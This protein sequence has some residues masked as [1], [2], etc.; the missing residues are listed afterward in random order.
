MTPEEPMEMQALPLALAQQPLWFLQRLDPSS[1]AYNVPLA[2]TLSGTLDAGRLRRALEA[3]VERHE[4]LRTTFESIEGEPVQVFH[5][6][7]EVPWEEIDLAGLPEDER[8]RAIAAIE[9]EEASRPFDLARGPLVRSRLARLADDEHVWFV[10]FHHVVF[11]GWSQEVLLDEL[12]RLYDPGAEAPPELPIQY[13]DFAAWQEE[14]LSG[15]RL[16]R[17]VAFWRRELEGYPTLL[18]LPTDSP[19]PARQSFRGA[20]VGATLPPEVWRRAEALADEAGATPFMIFLAI[21]TAVLHR[22]SGADRLLVGTPSA[23]R[24]HPDAEGLIGNFVNTLAIGCDLSGDPTFRELLGRVRERTVAALA[25]EEL[26]FVQ[27]VEAIDPERHP[28]FSPLAQVGVAVERFNLAARELAPGLT[29]ETRPPVVSTAKIDMILFVR[30]APEGV[31]L[32]LEHATDLF[33]RETAERWLAYVARLAENALADP[34]RRL[35]ELPLMAEEEKRLVLEEWPLPLD[36]ADAPR[37]ASAAGRW[38]TGLPAAFA[39]RAAEAP[40]AVAVEALGGPGGKTGICL[41]YAGLARRSAALA[42]RLRAA[43]VRR[44]TPVA[45]ALD[46]SPELVVALLAVVR[47]GGVYVPLDRSYPEERRRLM[48]EDAGVRTLLTSAALADGL[49]D[50][51]GIDVLRIG[52]PEDDGFGADGGWTDAPVGPDDAAYVI[53]TSGSTGKPKGVTATH[54]GVARLAL[55]ADFTRL[56]PDDTFLHLASI[57]FDAATLEVWGPLL[58][59]GRV[60]LFPAETPAPAA[61]RSALARHRA[62]RMFLTTALFDQLAD[63]PE[64]IPDSLLHLMTGGEQA[65]AAAFR[66]VLAARPGLALSN[67]YGPTENTTFS[68]HRRV[69]GPEEAA[70]PPPIGRAIA[71]STCWV[72]D[73]ALRP[74]PTGVEG[75]LLVGGDGLAHG[76]LGRPALTAERFVPHPFPLATRPGERLYRTG[77]LVRWLPGGDLDFRGRNDFQVKIRGFRIEPGEVEEALASAPGVEKALVVVR[78][79]AGEP[80]LVGYYVPRPGD[81]SG[82]G[83]TPDAVR[84]DLRRRLPLFMVPAALVAMEALP[85]NAQGKVDRAALPEPE[86]SSEAAGGADFEAPRTPLEEAIAS[87]WSEVLKVERVGVHDDFFA[88][89][90]HSLLATRILARLADDF[91]VEVPLADL[92]EAPTVAGL[93]TALGTLMMDDMEDLEEIEDES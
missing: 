11:D 83:A 72:L 69:A 78:P 42:A 40:D 55:G 61:V 50:L 93:T 21:W 9:E 64:A 2:M 18:R 26:M 33:R 92:F 12:G 36:R 46:R 63:E 23:G 86:R 17:L 53:Y 43:G 28:S 34:E 74:V 73:R 82:A 79:V 19:R 67:V 7:V 90:G 60:A 32:V 35:S 22:L 29:A 76:Y 51:G 88:L 54:R 31:R 4:A 1:S 56:G 57:S 13:A 91:G 38:E 24:F 59:G 15:E 47:A 62:T 10:T 80:A 27:L 3:V 16:E 65:N 30:P 41:T 25:H 81:G 77:D 14:E 8:R 75:E 89:G 71:G 45:L 6:A 48:I 84:E 58:T 68:T 70:V 49:G 20:A 39:A 87:L 52:G 44:G 37:P 85:V 66:A 5:P